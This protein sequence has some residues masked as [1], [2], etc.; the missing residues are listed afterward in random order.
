MAKELTLNDIDA[1][2][3]TLGYQTGPVAIDREVVDE[4]VR[5]YEQELKGGDDGK[6]VSETLADLRDERDGI[7]QERDDAQELVEQLREAATVAEDEDP[8]DCFEE[9]Q[10]LL[11]VE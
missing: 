3:T 8:M 4:L 11:G 7:A 5:V 10:H 1:L 2:K 9:V 6:S